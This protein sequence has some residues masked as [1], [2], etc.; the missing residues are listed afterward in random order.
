MK[1]LLSVAT[2]LTLGG[3]ALAAIAQP[4]ARPGQREPR[5]AEGAPGPRGP[6]GRPEFG[7]PPNPLIDVLDSDRDHEISAKEIDASAAA[8][9]KLD[10]N[11]DG[12]LSEDELRPAPPPGGPGGEGG[13]R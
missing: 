7:P 1:K 4:P 9:R 8:L 11:K 10:R 6:E 2:V 12:K 3:L 5:G 13:E